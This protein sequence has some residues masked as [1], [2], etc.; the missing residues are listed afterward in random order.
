MSQVL[1]VHTRAL[2]TKAVQYRKM[3]NVV[4]RANTRK[5]KTGDTKLYDESYVGDY[6][7][8]VELV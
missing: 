2:Q 4:V 7:D 3:A 8:S 6:L 1:S 5:G